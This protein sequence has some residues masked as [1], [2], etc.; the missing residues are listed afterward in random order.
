MRNEGEEGFFKND[1]N[2]SQFSFI[3]EGSKTKVVEVTECISV[4]R[5]RAKSDAGVLK[6]TR[7]MA[8]REDGVAGHTSAGPLPVVTEIPPEHMHFVL[9]YFMDEHDMTEGDA[10]A[11][12]SSRPGRQWYAV[13][14]GNHR[15]AALLRHAG[16]NPGEFAGFPWRVHVIRW[17]P[18]RILKGFA[19]ARNV[20]QQNKFL[21]E[22][23]LYD[24]LRS[25][26]DI[27]IEEV[28]LRGSISQYEEVVKE[29][30][31]NKI[32][33]DGFCGLDNYA[34]ATVIK[35]AGVVKNLSNETIATFGEI[36]TAEENGLMAERLQQAGFEFSQ[37][38]LHDTRVYKDFVSVSALRGALE[39]RRLS[40]EI[41]IVALHRLK[42]KFP[43]NRFKG[44][45]SC[46]LNSAANYAELALAEK[47]KMEVV[48]GSPVWPRSLKII[49]EN[50]LHTS[51][52]DEELT[53][54]AENRFEL[55]PS[56]SDAYRQAC[57]IQ[58]PFRIFLFSAHQLEASHPP[59]D[60]S[61]EV[62]G[63][64]EGREQEAQETPA[65]APSACVVSNGEEGV[66]TAA[67]QTEM[68][69]E[70][71]EATFTGGED[72]TSE[73][74]LGQDP[75]S[76]E[77]DLTLPP[78]DAAHI[79]PLK[80]C[81]SGEDELAT[82]DG[83]EHTGVGRDDR[84][85]LSDWN[86]RTHC[87]TP[88]VFGTTHFTK[89]SERFD[90]Y[91]GDPSQVE[92]NGGVRIELTDEDLDGHVKLAKRVLFPGSVFL[93]FTAP[94]D[95]GRWCSVLN[96]HEFNTL[97]FPFLLI[98]DEEYV[99]ANRSK[100]PQNL[101]EFV[102]VAY[103]PGVNKNHFTADVSTAYPPDVS[104]FRRRWAI[105]NK[106]PVPDLASR[107]LRSNTRSPVRPM[108]RSAQA[109]AEL[110]NTF[111]PTGG[112]VLDVRAGAME[113]GVACMLTNRSCM[114]LE[115]ES[116]CYK[117]AVAKLTS[118]AEDLEELEVN[119]KKVARRTRSSAPG[120]LQSLRITEGIRTGDR[121]SR[122][123]DEEY[124]S[125]V[126]NDSDSD[127]DRGSMENVPQDHPQLE[128][129][130]N[131]GY[132]DDAH[133]QQKNLPID[134][135]DVDGVSDLSGR[136][137]PEGATCILQSSLEPR[138]GASAV[139]AADGMDVL[140]AVAEQETRDQIVAQA[141]GQIGEYRKVQS[142]AERI[143]T[144]RSRGL[145]RGYRPEE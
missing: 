22:M 42:N 34:D 115:S 50:L 3:W 136:N 54:Y 142:I 28:L 53:E 40:S 135:G 32:V 112:N 87:I 104:T 64:S 2:L 111:C 98:R 122:S 113:T 12:M 69:F 85:F 100:K 6:L 99:Q 4:L 90:L 33:A 70:N 110:L 106:V 114:L 25:L 27:A 89:T 116:Y 41:Q 96:R 20:M 68:S 61:S 119:R 18:I 81:G 74:R 132:S 9:E 83:G 60:V 78:A 13:V 143:R 44:F 123:A 117:L 36:M 121:N 65:I 43:S 128:R 118:K 71:Q 137:V 17:Q 97:S 107:L 127:R 126:T 26:K 48:M 95:F 120:E 59:G 11:Q 140:A 139:N 77:A 130:P 24:T 10:E 21:V 31:F 63:D 82:G 105:M 14:D 55:I 37:D 103:S 73:Q 125:D 88:K 75:G 141:A 5:V 94:R 91:M 134:D 30:G 47:R 23:T 49:L 1:T 52:L 56:L 129:N 67:N 131:G 66:L 35:L 80:P 45:S 46:A 7:L 58:G 84:D 93:M 16:Q 102:V 57:P 39:F 108:Q 19:R 62:A 15:H 29:R 92:S 76:C 109:I 144:R 51:T 8:Q 133:A 72:A 38:D 101:A 138:E 86:I 124:V 79:L 145:L